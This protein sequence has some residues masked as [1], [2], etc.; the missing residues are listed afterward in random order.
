MAAFE[1]NARSLRSF[2]NGKFLIAVVIFYTCSHLIHVELITDEHNNAESYPDAD[3]HLVLQKP[4]QTVVNADGSASLSAS[5]NSRSQATG[6][7]GGVVGRGGG[8][9]TAMGATNNAN[10]NAA[11]LK[12]MVVGGSVN[13][14]YV[15]AKDL[16]A[17]QDAM[18]GIQPTVEGVD[19]T[20]M[21]DGMRMMLCGDPPNVATLIKAH[22]CESKVDPTALN[23]LQGIPLRPFLLP[24][25]AA[26]AAAAAASNEP[27]AGA[28]GGRGGGAVSF[29]GGVVG[30]QAHRRL[31]QQQQQQQR[32][33]NSVGDGT[34]VDDTDGE[35]EAGA[36]AAA[37][38]ADAA[39]G[40]SFAEVVSK[41]NRG[42]APVPGSGQVFVH[43]DNAM[44]FGRGLAADA[45]ADQTLIPPS[46]AAALDGHL[47]QTCSVVGSSGILRKTAYGAMIDSA[48]AVFRINQAPTIG[49]C[50][51]FTGGR[52]TVRVINAH[53]LHKYSHGDQLRRLPVAA[54]A[55]LVV[56]RYEKGDYTRL[57]ELW[58]RHRP[59]VKIRLLTRDTMHG[60]TLLLHS[61]QA[62]PI[63]YS[64][65][66]P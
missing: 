45:D 54:N 63:V 41:V 16:Q 24:T 58:R 35:D 61:Y 30:Y 42:L 10:P 32:D 56:T 7:G 59:D 21:S 31:Q 53:W 33:F 15:S 43:R 28:G 20:S 46:E 6:V 4:T 25:N 12:P 50:A 39:E 44:L 27:A 2:F 57:V 26:A 9:T 37:A 52:T 14:K 60:A 18:N 38:A 23:G 62:A 36:T 1:F 11:D 29:G 51:L 55:T 19:R 34:G 8:A 66:T 17:A 5:E 47:Y 65:F 40:E 64:R 13:G 49:G 22:Y 3:Q 48:D